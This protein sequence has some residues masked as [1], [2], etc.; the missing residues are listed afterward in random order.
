MLVYCRVENMHIWHTDPGI[1]TLLKLKFIMDSKLSKI[2]WKRIEEF[3]TKHVDVQIYHEA[4]V[5]QM[6]LAGSTEL[7]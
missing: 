1:N 7:P 6:R 5:S 2:S 4:E 3:L